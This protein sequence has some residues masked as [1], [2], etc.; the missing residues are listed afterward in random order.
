VDAESVI[1]NV[2]VSAEVPIIESS[3]V[4]PALTRSSGRPEYR[5]RHAG[6]GWLRLWAPVLKGASTIVMV[7]LLL[8]WVDW[9]GSLARL[10][11]AA[12]GWILLVGFLVVR[13]IVVSAW[14][15]QLLLRARMMPVA[16]WTLVRFY[17]IGIFFNNVMPTSVGGDVARLALARHIGGLAAVAASMLVERATGFLVLLVVCLFVL[18][19]PGA[20]GVYGREL[21]GGVVTL[22]LV[23]IGLLTLLLWRGVHTVRLVEDLTGGRGGPFSSILQQLEKLTRKLAEYGQDA[24]TMLTICAVSIVFNGVLVVSHYAVIKAVHADLSIWVVARIAPLVVLAS[25]LPVSINGLGITESAFVLL[26][27][28]VGLAPEVALAAAVL[29]RLVVVSMSLVGAVLWLLHHP[30]T[31]SQ[32]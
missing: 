18:L 1:K 20:A 23:A 21:Q 15:W 31:P 12:D 9:R 6:K 26:Y 3:N 24:P 19:L 10:G 17:W 4:N 14:K 2:F 22:L 8:C 28:Q 27:A 5:H 11:G 16:L 29:R 30:V 13:S 32:D 25:A 7:T